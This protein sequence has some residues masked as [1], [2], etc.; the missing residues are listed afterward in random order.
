ML[1]IVMSAVFTVYHVEARCV[2]RYSD[3]ETVAPVSAEVAS[4]AEDE[5]KYQNIFLF[6]EE[7]LLEQVNLRV[8]RA[9]AVDVECKFPNTVQVKYKLVNEDI[10]IKTADGYVVAGSSGKIIISDSI[11][12]T[13][14]ASG[15]EYNDSLIKVTPYS[16]PDNSGVGEYLYNDRS[17]YDLTALNILLEYSSSLV[18]PDTFEEVFRPSYESIDLSSSSIITIKMERGITFRLNSRTSARFDKDIASLRQAVTA[19]VSWYVDVAVKNDL[20][21]GTA[22]VGYSDA[23]QGFTVQWNG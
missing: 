16:S 3:I 20:G 8:A 19:M 2:S 23:A 10:Q 9:E 5:I 17:G 7:E 21:N 22:T 14:V 18:T 11:D 12:R 13:D 1:I 4:V 6:D 15:V